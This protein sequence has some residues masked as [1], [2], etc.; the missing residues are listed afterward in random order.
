MD[1]S[2]MFKPGDLLLNKT[3]FVIV[4]RIMSSSNSIEVY[5]YS[6][7]TQTIMVEIVTDIIFAKV[8]E[9]IGTMTDDTFM[10]NLNATTLLSRCK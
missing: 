8:A 10:L 6:I 9:V 4:R 1:Y 3:T 7:S 5:R 2:K